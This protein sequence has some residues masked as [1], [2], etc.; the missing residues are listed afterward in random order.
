MKVGLYSITYLGVWYDGPALTF[1]DF[2]K[3]AKA[4][5]YAGIELDGKRP[6]GNPMDLDRRTR[7]QMRDVLE[8]ERPQ[9]SC[10]QPRD[11]LWPSKSRAR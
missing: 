2:V 1:E 7:D 4:Y 6:H 11:C 5:G 10:C 9:A 3:R 8:R